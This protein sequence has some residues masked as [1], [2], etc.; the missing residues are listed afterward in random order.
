H[1]SCTEETQLA[2][3]RARAATGRRRIVRFLTHF[4]GWHDHAAGGVHDHFDGSPNA[5]GLGEVA[6]SS[7]AVAPNDIAAVE[8]ILADKDVAA[9]MLEPVGSSSGMVPTPPEVLGLLR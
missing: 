9:V 8:R 7:A 2:M 5:G 3:R 6:G 1:S 4:H